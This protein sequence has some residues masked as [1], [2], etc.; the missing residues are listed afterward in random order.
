MVLSGGRTVSF[1]LLTSQNPNTIAANIA[2]SF[3]EAD[4]YAVPQLIATG[5]VLFVIT[6]LVNMAGRAITGGPKPDRAA[7][8]KKRVGKESK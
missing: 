8:E 5:L 6:F 2:L 1:Q 4:S 7:R 3:P